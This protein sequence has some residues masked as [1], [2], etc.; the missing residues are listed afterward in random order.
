M[1]VLPPYYS[2][3]YI[4]RVGNFVVPGAAAT[5]D[6]FFS[7]GATPEGVPLTVATEVRT[8][9]LPL[10][11]VSIDEVRG[12]LRDPSTSGTVTVNVKVN[13]TSLFSTN[14]TIDANETT[15]VTAAAPF[16][17]SPGNHGPFA[18][19]SEVTVDIVGA[20]TGATG[21]NITLIGTRAA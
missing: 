21:L 15:S 20:G 9:R 11:F 14:L 3:V 1:T 6:A 13:G 2:L 12:S 19:D 8:V 7:F 16:V 17:L 5:A 4:Q 18:D 10:A